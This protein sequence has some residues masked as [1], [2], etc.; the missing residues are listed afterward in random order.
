MS[1]I[2][3]IWNS[4]MIVVV[5]LQSLRNATTDSH[6]PQEFQ[7]K[8]SRTSYLLLKT[9][10]RADMCMQ[11]N[12]PLYPCELNVLGQKRGSIRAIVAS[13]W[14]V[15]IS[16][17]ISVVAIDDHWLVTRLLPGTERGSPLLKMTHW[18]TSMTSAGPSRWYNAYSLGWKHS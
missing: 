16:W 11:Y 12:T 7:N 8:Q 15:R 17:I 9:D 13:C 5:V 6:A 1:I 18:R 3:H 2:S 4:G 10:G 14:W